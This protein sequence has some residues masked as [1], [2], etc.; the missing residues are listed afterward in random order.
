[1]KHLRRH[2]QSEC[3]VAKA[4][5]SLLEHAAQRKKNDKE[6]C[7]TVSLEETSNSPLPQSPATEAQVIVTEDEE[8]KPGSTGHFIVC[9]KC[10]EGMKAS[11]LPLHLS[12]CCVLRTIMCPNIHRGCDQKEIPLK[13]LQSHLLNDCKAEKK[14]QELIEKSKL[15]REEVVCSGCGELVPILFL[16]RHESELCENRRVHCRNHALGCNVMVRMRE[17]S[18]HELVDGRKQTRS[19]FYTVGHGVNLSIGEDDI[20]GSWTTEVGK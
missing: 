14:R 2:I 9:W 13:Q 3:V 16:K 19:S 5:K 18:L 6:E 4:R 8:V 12:E 10:N 15:R 20:K 1:M 7:L 17:R 11:Q